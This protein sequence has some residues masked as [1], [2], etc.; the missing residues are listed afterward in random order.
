MTENNSAL[1]RFVLES[2]QRY[3]QT[4]VLIDDRI[5]DSSSGSVTAQLT[6]PT[7]MQRKSALKSANISSVTEEKA[8][9]QDGEAV[10]VDE[11]SFHDVQ[12]SFAKQRIICS[13][14]QPEK[15]AQVN[16][17]SEI[18]RLCSAADVVVI[19][20]DL[21]G[22]PG[23]MAKELVG[24]LIEQSIKEIPHQLRLILIY[25]MEANLG[26]V[27]NELFETLNERIEDKDIGVEQELIL[28]TENSRLVVLGK[29][30]N[31]NYSQYTPFIVS[32]EDLASRTI[33][34]F[35]QLASGLLQSIILRGIAALRE[36]NRRILTRFEDR[37]DVAFLTNRSLLLPEES[38]GQIVT[39][40]T[41]EIRAVL[42]D[43]LG[44][45][46]LGDKSSTDLIIQDWVLKCW[47]HGDDFRTYIGNDGDSRGLASEMFCKGKSLEKGFTSFHRPQDKG[48]TIDWEKDRR[49]LKWADFL[50]GNK[51]SYELHPALAAL[52]CQ[53][54]FYENVKRNLRLGV[55]LK[56][57]SDNPDSEGDDNL[58]LLC[59]QPVCDSVRLDR[60]P[61]TFIFCRMEFA[62]DSSKYTHILISSSR[63]LIRLKYKP[64]STNIIVVEFLPD[65]DTINAV[66][67]QNRF[68]FRD[69]RS[70]EYEWIAEL[71]PE[72]AQ[73][74]A[75]Q[76]GSVLSR[77]GLNES[78]WLRL[79][80]KKN[81]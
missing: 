75:E 46:P 10:P 25:T 48:L 37:L 79:K 29:R 63:E 1:N 64:S 81:S 72:H 60:K 35:S 49:T 39:L 33:I 13:L 45:Y 59:L 55:I 8:V 42:E 78:E 67:D 65:S 53:R 61:C 5:Y 32:E 22:N 36:N 77:V 66:K 54:V 34:E 71:K 18:Y 58:F 19:D 68:I 43:R 2:A 70:K 80:G 12:N 15:T 11:A 7:V 23:V 26:G 28:T 27:A 51:S 52:M 30:L 6:R 41:D 47:N 14:Y 21:Y 76:F 50:V 69:I 24:N 40:L 31:D 74:A 44:E 17:D 56:T 4:V 3:L 9:S 16:S 38:F 20:W 62:S 73:R 57:I